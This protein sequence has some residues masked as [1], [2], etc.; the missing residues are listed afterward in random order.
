MQMVD[1]ALVRHADCVVILTVI[2]LEAHLTVTGS[3]G[4]VVDADEVQSTV[5]AGVRY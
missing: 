2:G 4:F 1:V 5:S 3:S